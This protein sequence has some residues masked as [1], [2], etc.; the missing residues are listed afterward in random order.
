MA[1][2][3]FE[4]RPS[5]A[6]ILEYSGGR[7]GVSAVPGSG[8]TWTLSNL[9]AK[10]VRETN[11]KRG[12]Q[13]LV[14]TLVNSA[15]GKFEQQVRSFLGEGTLG[16]LFR[17]RT[18]HGLANDIVSE[19]PGLVGLADNFEILDEI[20]ARQIINDAV[21]AWFNAHKDFGVEAYFS[22][23]H[24]SKDRSRRDWRKKKR[25]SGSL[26]THSKA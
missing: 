25:L 6:R 22:E 14:V 15:R 9:A 2:T 1:N 3:N 19:R 16:T 7:M 23:E 11:L 4:P 18:L 8:K 10:L 5:Q 13:I 17:V 20:E 12:Q 21:I 26:H 24:L